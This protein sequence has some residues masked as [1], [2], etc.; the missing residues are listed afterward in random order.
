M[1]IVGYLI[2]SELTNNKT[3]RY[4]TALLSGFMPLF[5][6]ETLNSISIYSL[7]IPLTFLNIYF[8]MKIIDYQN[9]FILYFIISLMVLRTTTPMTVFLIFSYLLYLLFVWIEG[10]KRLKA[11]T[12]LILFSTFAI[13]WTLFVF[14]KDA[15]LNYGLSILWQNTPQELL[16][17][18]FAN[19]NILSMIY[20]IGII[21]LIF[22]LYALYKYIFIEKDKKTY[23]LIS[24]ALITLFLMWLRFIELN[25]AL[26]FIGFIFIFLFA[27]TYDSIL[28]KINKIGYKNTLT[29]IL[30]IIIVVS[31]IIPSFT[32][33]SEKIKN[34]FKANEIE[35]LFWL[36]QNANDNE[37]VLSSLEEG[38]LISGIARKK[39][40]IDSNFMFVKGIDQRIIDART[41]YT[42]TSQTQRVG[43]LNKYNINYIYFSNR[44]KKEFNIESIPYLDE[45]CFEKVFS[46]DE[47]E[48]YK[49]LCIIEEK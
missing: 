29:I 6:S 1:V 49:S 39:N 36:R 37:T 32:L 4:L 3:G 10:M 45:N 44:S 31:S 19:A 40:F 21:P 15:F 47:V 33:G 25:T 41:I 27:K 14:F 43:L 23:L 11:E 9:N 34:S 46:N 18:Y 8:M 26:M 13:T 20:L 38:N 22:G 12:E 7:F 2:A 42:T 5:F 35:A 28:L 17:N 48:I 16:K 24:F 30:L